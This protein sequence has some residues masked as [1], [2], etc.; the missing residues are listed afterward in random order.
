MVWEPLL[1][2][3]FH[4]IGK[5][6]RRLAADESGVWV[7]EPTFLA[8]L[9]AVTDRKD[10]RITFDDGNGSDA[11]HALPALLDRGLSATFFIV[12]G[13]VGEP[14]FVDAAAL[15]ELAGHGMSIGCHGMRHRPW[16]GLGPSA[17]HEEL[18]EARARLEEIVQA[19]VTEVACPFGNYDRRV[20]QAVRK[21]GYRR[22]YT[23]DRGL[24]R[25]GDFVQPRTSVHAG[26]TPALL[27]AI[28]S[29][30]GRAHR[31][32]PR[33]AKLAVKRWR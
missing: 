30:H 23:S 6:P 24:S 14:G 27:G 29:A 3:T 31:S 5:P 33:R 20:L 12:S 22:A 10:V 16:R 26:D 32:L 18:V 1:N 8:M 15:R 2:L 4:G 17:L 11:Q 13:R 21:C 19:P 7:S 28:P 9:D 25:P